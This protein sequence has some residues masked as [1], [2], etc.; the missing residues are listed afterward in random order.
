MRPYE[1]GVLFPEEMTSQAGQTAPSEA[2]PVCETPDYTLVT[3]SG[4]A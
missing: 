1:Q 4:S 3:E 2:L